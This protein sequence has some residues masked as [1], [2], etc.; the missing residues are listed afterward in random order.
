[1]ELERKDLNASMKETHMKR[2]ISEE[3]SLNSNERCMPISEA[4]SAAIHDVD[5]VAAKRVKTS[6][7][8]HD[9]EGQL[10][11]SSPAKWVVL[12]IGSQEGIVLLQRLQL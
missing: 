4:F 6:Y 12:I 11:F 9:E 10:M 3:N 7:T 1:M 5:K 2:I 8:P